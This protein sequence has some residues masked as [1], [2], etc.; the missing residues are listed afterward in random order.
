MQENNDHAGSAG[1]QNRHGIVF[2]N[3]VQNEN[4]REKSGTQLIYYKSN[5]PH[6]LWD[7]EDNL[8]WRQMKYAFSEL[9][10][11]TKLL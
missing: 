7:T 9:C 8:W 4:Y 10:V 5:A 3:G 11:D 1:S 6:A 2:K